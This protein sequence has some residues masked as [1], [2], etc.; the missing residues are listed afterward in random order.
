MKLPAIEVIEYDKT[1][2]FNYLRKNQEKKIKQQ[3][4]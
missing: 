3:I 4:K 1:F 2:K